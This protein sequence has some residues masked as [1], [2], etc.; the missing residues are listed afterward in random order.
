M[1]IY[2][3]YG[4][5]EPMDYGRQIACCNIRRFWVVRNYDDVADYERAQADQEEIEVITDKEFEKMFGYKFDPKE[6]EFSGEMEI[7]MPD[8]F[9]NEDK[10]GK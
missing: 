9:E 8:H 2:E 3:K 5:S 1:C 6:F 4:R 7:D 10:D